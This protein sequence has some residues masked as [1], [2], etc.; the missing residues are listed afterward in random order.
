VLYPN[1]L[2]FFE[3]AATAATEGRA[4]LEDRVDRVEARLDALDE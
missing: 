1:R 4:R 3:R 2:S